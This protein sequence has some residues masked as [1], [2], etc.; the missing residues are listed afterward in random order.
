MAPRCLMRVA[1]IDYHI[2]EGLFFRQSNF[3][4]LNIF[5]REA[6]VYSKT[7]QSVQKPLSKA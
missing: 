2:S 6:N 3:T 7:N 4:L 1:A 5:S